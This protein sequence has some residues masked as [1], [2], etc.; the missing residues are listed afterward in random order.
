MAIYHDR[1]SDFRDEIRELLVNQPVSRE[2]I[3]VLLVKV[4]EDEL[5]EY[6]TLCGVQTMLQFYYVINYLCSCN[7]FL[8]A[9]VAIY[10]KNL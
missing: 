4:K 10:S 7:I 2:K 5:T 9:T 1:F 3:L 8:A 6:S